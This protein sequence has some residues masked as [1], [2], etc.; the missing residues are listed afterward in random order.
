MSRY[1]VVLMNGPPWGLRLQGTREPDQFLRVAKINPNSKAATAGVGEGDIVEKINGYNVQGTDLQ[2]AQLLVKNAGKRLELHLKRSEE[3]N[4]IPNGPQRRNREMENSTPGDLHWSWGSLYAGREEPTSS[5]KSQEPPQSQ[6]PHYDVA[7]TYPT[8]DRN[9]D[10]SE[11]LSSVGLGAGKNYVPAERDLHQTYVKHPRDDASVPERP[12]FRA[13]YVEPMD[14][15]YKEDGYGRRDKMEGFSPRRATSSSRALMQARYG[16]AAPRYETPAERYAR[17]WNERYG[18]A[19]SGYMQADD[20]RNAPVEEPYAS[21]NTTGY[22][23]DQYYHRPA[24]REGNSKGGQVKSIEESSRLSQQPVQG[25]SKNPTEGGSLYQ[26]R[27]VEVQADDDFAQESLSPASREVVEV[28]NPYSDSEKNDYNL[29]DSLHF[30][31]IEA[32]AV[33]H[34]KQPQEKQPPEKQPQE[35]RFSATAEAKKLQN[36]RSHRAGKSYYT[37]RRPVSMATF[38]RNNR[39]SHGQAMFRKR[40]SWHA[41]LQHEPRESP[42][43]PVA[44][45]YGSVTMIAGKMQQ[46]G[47]GGAAGKSPKGKVSSVDMPTSGSVPPARQRERSP[48]KTEQRNVAPKRPETIVVD[49][50]ANEKMSLR[51]R[52]PS[53]TFNAVRASPT[54]GVWSPTC[55]TPP[56]ETEGDTHLAD[57][58]NLKNQ[59]H[60]WS[61]SNV[62]PSPT[63]ARKGFKSI[64]VDLKGPQN[65]PQGPPP[66]TP[67]ESYLWKPASG[68][69]SSTPPSSS[70]RSPSPSV[71][72]RSP[73]PAPVAQT[74]ASYRVD[75]APKTTSSP[76]PWRA[77]RSRSPSPNRP[78]V[79]GPT[80]Q[81]VEAR[82]SPVRINSPGK[83]ISVEGRLV[84]PVAS[85]PPRVLSPLVSQKE[86][87]GRSPRSA[88]AAEVVQKAIS[89]RLKKVSPSDSSETSL[90]PTTSSMAKK[91]TH[92]SSEVKVQ[93]QHGRVNGVERSLSPESTSSLPKTE[94]PTTT[95][96]KH[97]RLPPEKREERHTEH[98]HDNANKLASGRYITPKTDLPDGAVYQEKIVEG[99]VVHTDTYYPMRE[100]KTTKTYHVVDSKEVKFEGA[101]PQDESG[102]PTSTRSHRTT[103]RLTGKSGVS[104]STRASVENQKDWYKKMFKSMH[105]TG[106]KGDLEN[107]YKPT[108][109]FP[110]DDKDVTRYRDESFRMRYSGEFSPTEFESA[111]TAQ[112]KP[113]R[114]SISYEP[115]YARLGSSNNNNSSDKSGRRSPTVAPVNPGR[116]EDYTPGR[117]ALGKP[118]KP[119]SQERRPSLEDELWYQ[120]LVEKEQPLPFR[121][122]DY[123]PGKSSIL[124]KGREAAA[125]QSSIYNPYMEDKNVKQALKVSVTKAAQGETANSQAEEKPS[126]ELYKQIQSGGDIPTMGLRKAAPEKPKDDSVFE[127][128]V[129]QYRA[130]ISREPVIGPIP[131]ATRTTS[132]SRVSASS[133]STGKRLSAAEQLGV[134]SAPPTKVKGPESPNATFKW[135]LDE[136]FRSIYSPE[137]GGMP[138]EFN[139]PSRAEPGQRTEIRYQVQDNRD[140]ARV[141][142]SARSR[143]EEELRW[144]REEERRQGRVGRRKVRGSSPTRPPFPVDALL[145]EIEGYVRELEAFQQWEGETGSQKAQLSPPPVPPPPVPPPP[146]EVQTP[147]EETSPTTEA[148]PVPPLPKKK[149][150]PPDPPPRMDLLRKKISRKEELNRILEEERRKKMVEEEAQQRARKHSANAER[151]VVVPSNRYDDTQVTP[152]TKISIEVKKE[153]S[154]PSFEASPEILHAQR[155][156]PVH[157]GALPL[158]THNNNEQSG[159]RA[160]AR[161]L[162]PFKAQNSKELSFKKGD[163]IYLTRQVDKNWYEGEHNG[164]VGIFPVNYIEVITSLEEAQ[165]TASQ[166]SEGSARAKYSFVGETQ[167]ELSLKKNDIVTLLRRV[168]SNWYEGQIGNRQGIFPVSYVEVF[169]EPGDSTPTDLSPPAQPQSY[170]HKASPPVARKPISPR[171]QRTPSPQVPNQQFYSNNRDN[172]VYNGGPHP[173]SAPPPQHHVP[174]PQHV[175]P[176][177]HI[178]PPQHVPPQ[179]VSPPVQTHANAMPPPPS[180]EKYRA[181]Y[182]YHP[183]NED[184]LELTED[185]VVLV[186]EKCDDGWYVGTSQRTGQF[187]TFPGNYVVEICRAG[188]PHKLVPWDKS[189]PWTS[190]MAHNSYVCESLALPFSPALHSK[191]TRG[192]TSL[193]PSCAVTVTP[194]MLYL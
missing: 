147:K 89:P 166:G 110:E 81:F 133:T 79:N 170:I 14:D 32:D 115:R 189:Q 47:T 61:P 54:P 149:G 45:G 128:E 43:S 69:A 121:I 6:P 135:S 86:P 163:V 62:P 188:S 118:G 186:M 51:T 5:S 49:D 155:V 134:K 60:T 148:P 141:M 156:R 12:L 53:P 162:Y 55:P 35:T 185:D 31:P 160:H 29:P 109:S 48:A 96:L 15:E 50:V 74:S 104:T 103:E 52:A 27:H 66:P 87:P 26:A 177:Q 159:L 172:Y 9:E 124:D 22:R 4:R 153:P 112:A 113:N 95:L 80:E 83:L 58:V 129:V 88:A 91:L 127:P 30:K 78:E 93:V 150:P 75:N 167:V 145:A 11:S 131:G 178:S 191:V 183:Q 17:H 68:T 184:E 151:P 3:N 144:Q 76:I 98:V 73:V 139:G 16:D 64:R 142:E 105:D 100:P 192:V 70:W 122:E 190:Q 38:I 13:T 67:E 63:A 117:G 42:T 101:G 56:L 179:H 40:H 182:S 168:D 107:S 21:A 1:A 24:Q 146:T 171:A 90:S 173:R 20:S 10:K 102:M 99:D 140:A 36:R 77:S 71:S 34:E 120:F 123:E 72:R 23:D 41:A 106:K 116:I 125:K 132:T 176:P 154:P 138:G 180:G 130:P 114:A 169:K 164:Y 65:R 111:T 28:F 174:P 82:S 46:T 165:K 2:Q 19:V 59:P 119:H 194:E 152:P 158:T 143:N 84:S 8:V 94:S 126:R 25:T 18:T 44:K 57:E 108:Y 7:H 85:R 157:V 37:H 97:H 175:S 161:A 137:S 92:S 33:P 187:G 193:T 181:I 136:Y 39:P